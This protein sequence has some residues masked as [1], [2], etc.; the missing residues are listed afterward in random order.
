[1]PSWGEILNRKNQGESIDDIT[2]EEV[3]SVTDDVLSLAKK[4]ERKN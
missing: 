4:L 3:E 1:M 2:K